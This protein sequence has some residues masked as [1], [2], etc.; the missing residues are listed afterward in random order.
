MRLIQAG[1]YLMG[2]TLEQIEVARHLNMGGHEFTWL[3]ETPQF[4][5]SIAASRLISGLQTD[6]APRL[7]ETTLAG[8]SASTNRTDFNKENGL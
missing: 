5:A 6:C 3:D 7:P 8:L 1:D 2:S 4:R